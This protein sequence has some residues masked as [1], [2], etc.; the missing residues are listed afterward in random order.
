MGKGSVL[1]IELDYPSKK[2]L[3]EIITEKLVEMFPNNSVIRIDDKGE[4]IVGD[5]VKDV[6]MDALRLKI[7]IG[8][9]GKKGETL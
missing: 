6:V 8:P 9:L 5:A 2:K 7:T 1:T 3:K 4:V